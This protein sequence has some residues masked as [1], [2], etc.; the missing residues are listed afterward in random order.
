M[1]NLFIYIYDIFI[2]IYIHLHK[3][4][5]RRSSNQSSIFFVAP[6]TLAAVGFP[7]EACGALPL[8][9]LSQDARYLCAS[10][11]GFRGWL[12]GWLVEGPPPRNMALIRPI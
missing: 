1:Y 4:I 5:N 12:V 7:R 8:R 3:Y 6:K 11:R 2:Y 9:G 10:V